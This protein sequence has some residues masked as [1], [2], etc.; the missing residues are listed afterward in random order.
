ML[1]RSWA[2]IVFV[3][4]ALAE[5]L[6]LAPVPDLSLCLIQPE[7][8]QQTTNDNKPKYC[9]ALHV[10]AALA[11]EGTDTFLERHDKSVVGAFTIVLAI[12]TIGLWLATNKL[13]DAARNQ[14]TH[15]EETAKRQLRAY[16]NMTN[17]HLEYLTSFSQRLEAY[18]VFTNSGQTPAYSVRNS[19][20]FAISRTGEEVFNNLPAQRESSSTVGR[21]GSVNKKLIAPRLL[22]QADY[23]GLGNG[24]L[25][26][27]VYGRL[28]YK[29]AFG[30][31]HFTNY[32]M[33]IGGDVGISPSGGMAMAEQGNETDDG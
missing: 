32:R 28:T 5:V 19:G 25:T 22:T 7:H 15:S 26:L 3:Y 23:S 27:W 17:C 18:V 11:I 10:A 14:F 16:I 8:S 24:S 21:D 33:L 12:S 30:G 9:P 20:N 29:D 31:D 4:L 13:W 6:S 2:L 1:K